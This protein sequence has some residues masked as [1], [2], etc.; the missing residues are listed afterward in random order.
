MDEQLEIC[1]ARDDISVA[2]CDDIPFKTTTIEVI[3]EFLMEDGSGFKPE[4][5][6][7]I[8]LSNQLDEEVLIGYEPLHDWF[9][10]NRTHSGN[11]EF[12]KT[13][14]GDHLS[15]SE[16]AVGHYTVPFQIRDDRVRMHLLIDVASVELFADRGSLAMTEIFFPT[17][18]F[19]RLSLFS[20]NGQIRIIHG[21]IYH[22]ESIWRKRP[23]P[24]EY[25]N[26]DNLVASNEWGDI[27]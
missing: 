13:E 12:L 16:V 2:K 15:S 10:V 1:P 23:I 4:T 22:L 19:N 7:G 26:L 11:T 17:E 24:F 27:P 9:F 3:L 6:F 21:M 14:E 8:R 18:D 25:L 20:V 5:G